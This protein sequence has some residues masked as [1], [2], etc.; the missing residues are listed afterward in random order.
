[1][2]T[3]AVFMQNHPFSDNVSMHDLFVG[4]PNGLRPVFPKP[5]VSAS[6]LR[7]FLDSHQCCRLTPELVTLVNDAWDV[8]PARRPSFVVIKARLAD[9]VQRSAEPETLCVRQATTPTDDDD[10]EELDIGDPIPPAREAAAVMGRHLKFEDFE[11]SLI[12]LPGSIEEK[13]Y[14]K[15]EIEGFV[16]LKQVGSLRRPPDLRQIRFSE[17]SSADV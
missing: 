11:D 14:S 17:T 8:D 5:E 10:D 9:V 13:I 4:V 12:P 7:S 1:M 6:E 2:V 16:P 3:Y 15:G